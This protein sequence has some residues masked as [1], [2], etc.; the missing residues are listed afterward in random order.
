[1]LNKSNE[2][3]FFR[4]TAI[5]RKV[6]E[7]F[8]KY[9]S[10]FIK[11][12]G[13]DHRYASFDF[14][15]SY[16]YRTHVLNMGENEDKE[17]SCMVLWSYLASWGMLRGSSHLLQKSPA[18][19]LDLIDYI[20]TIYEDAIKIDVDSYNDETITKLIDIYKNVE[21]RLA[22]PN[23][24]KPSVTLVTK[25]MLGV[26]ANV[27]AYDQYVKK[28]FGINTFN[29]KSLKVI[30]EYYNEYNKDGAVDQLAEMQDVLVFPNIEGVE[31]TY[32]K[33]KIID[34]YGFQ[35]GISEE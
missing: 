25:I 9:V 34:M 28:A 8:E 13:V 16:F 14:C 23:K 20:R 31:L 6:M 5:E 7:D 33:A 4:L 3:I 19:L 22:I 18:Y 30:V 1:M 12:V 35:K 15:Y 26:F 11:K 24:F 32:T 27:P 29:K 2:I 21:S 17:K 10:M